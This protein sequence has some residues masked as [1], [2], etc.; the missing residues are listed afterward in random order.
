MSPDYHIRRATI[1]DAAVI[2]HHRAAMFRDMG[3]LDEEE[4]ATL[5]AETLAYLTEMLP[6]NKYFG[7][8]VESHGVVVA[9]AGL[10]VRRML[11]RPGNLQGGAEAY[12]LNIYTEPE[13]R[14]QGL[15]RELMKTVLGWCREQHIARITL[16]ASDDGRALYEGLGFVPTNEMR[17]EE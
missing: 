12:I 3:L 2:S 10:I 5:E 7:W 15:A 4:A 9:G 16:H 11:P 1:D 14:R 13:L 8:L 6:A 17:L